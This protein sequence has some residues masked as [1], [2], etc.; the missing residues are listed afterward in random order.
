MEIHSRPDHVMTVPEFEGYTPAQMEYHLELCSQAG[1]LLS[2][3]TFRAH[4]RGAAHMA[5]TRG[6]GRLMPY[7]GTALAI[8]QAAIR[9]D[10]EY[11][12]GHDVLARESAAFAQADIDAHIEAT[13][14]ALRGA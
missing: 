3:E 11:P 9:A 7:A 14:A 8:A 2:T 6:I 4:E 12:H 5:R 13:R 10:E 1:Y